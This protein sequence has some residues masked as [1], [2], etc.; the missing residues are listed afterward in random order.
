MRRLTNTLKLPT[1]V[2]TEITLK[3]TLTPEYVEK[4][5]GVDI[6]LSEWGQFCKEFKNW[7]LLEY[8]GTIEWMVDEW[9]NIKSGQL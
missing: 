6:P 7:Y 8:D 2:E 4:L 1:K 5:T 3:I 9:D